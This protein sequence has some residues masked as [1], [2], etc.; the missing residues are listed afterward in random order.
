MKTQSTSSTSALE[1]VTVWSPD[2][3]VTKSAMQIVALIILQ[4]LKEDR[5]MTI[6]KMILRW[7]VFK[8]CALRLQLM[9]IQD[10]KIE[11]VNGRSSW[12]VGRCGK[13]ELTYS[14]LEVLARWVEVKCADSTR[15]R[16][17]HSSRRHLLEWLRRGDYFYFLCSTVDI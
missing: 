15:F 6:R 5:W 8:Q 1:W 14:R 11:V 2:A 13:R 12:V 3:T 10:H 9:L 17:K 7:S 16:T 4:N